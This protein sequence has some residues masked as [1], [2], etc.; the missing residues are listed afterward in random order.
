MELQ[1]QKINGMYVAEFKATSD[2]ALHV[3]KQ[4]SIRL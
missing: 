1:F 3:E 4:E 2:F